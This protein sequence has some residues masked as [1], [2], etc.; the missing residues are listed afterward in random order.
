MVHCIHYCIPQVFIFSYFDV[1]HIDFIVIDQ[2]LKSVGAYFRSCNLI[3]GSMPVLA[4]HSNSKLGKTKSTSILHKGWKNVNM[5]NRS[6]CVG[7][8]FLQ[9][10][11][12]SQS[13]YRDILKAKPY[14]ESQN[15][16]EFHCS[17][18]EESWLSLRAEV[19]ATA[20]WQT[21][22]GGQAKQTKLGGS[23]ST[24]GRQSLAANPGLVL[25]A[26]K[27]SL[28]SE[29]KLHFIEGTNNF[30]TKRTYLWQA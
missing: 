22:L 12:V 5:F 23:P 2:S 30:K 7:Q 11:Q 8:Y 1:L 13:I 16:T 20:W 10:R 18:V 26:M 17:A 24:A 3:P 4:Q 25:S 15:V 29:C 28:H 21:K 6:R 27:C 9:Q 19:A 14:L